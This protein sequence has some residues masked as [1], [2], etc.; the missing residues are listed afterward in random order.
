MGWGSSFQRV[1]YH[2]FYAGKK[3]WNKPPMQGTAAE[4]AMV[5]TTPLFGS[6]MGN[7]HPTF[8][9]G[10]LILS[11]NAPT[12][13]V[14]WPCP[15]V[16]KL[17]W[18]PP[19]MMDFWKTCAVCPLLQI[20]RHFGVSMLHFQVGGSVPLAIFFLGK[21]VTIGKIPPESWFQRN[22]LIGEITSTG[23]VKRG[24]KRQRVV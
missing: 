1:L 9:G 20:W 24:D 3:S 19:K 14:W 5:S 23:M 10:I 4:N 21:H 15:T 7:G 13:F 11:I 6:Y 12:I 16:G 18:I 22:P 17:T 8:S 2:G